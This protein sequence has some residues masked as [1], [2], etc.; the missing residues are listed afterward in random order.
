VEAETPIYCSHTGKLCHTERRVLLRMPIGPHSH[1]AP[2][3]VPVLQV[4]W[5]A[6]LDD[7]VPGRVR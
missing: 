7:A 1:P 3:R 6:F 4:G 5:G 2:P